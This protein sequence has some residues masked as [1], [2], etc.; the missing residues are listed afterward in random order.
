LW[1][2]LTSATFDEVRNKFNK[3]DT[4]KNDVY[5]G[6]RLAAANFKIGNLGVF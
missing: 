1:I 5:D 6:G 2:A 4:M 3:K